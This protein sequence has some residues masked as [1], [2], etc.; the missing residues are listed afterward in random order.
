MQNKIP[1]INRDN[2]IEYFFKNNKNSMLNNNKCLFKERRNAVTS[3]LFPLGQ[4]TPL[5]R[6][7]GNIYRVKQKNKK[8]VEIWR[9]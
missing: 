8:K 6:K 5:H 3:I 4:Y 1:K 9:A 2:Y 7:H